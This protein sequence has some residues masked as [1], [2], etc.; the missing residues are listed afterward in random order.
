MLTSLLDSVD[1]GNVT[2]I[3]QRTV[4]RYTVPQRL[5]SACV[6]TQQLYKVNECRLWEMLSAFADE[7]GEVD[8]QDMVALEA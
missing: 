5:G 4:G 8:E 6:V 2:E 1:L 3:L 7:W